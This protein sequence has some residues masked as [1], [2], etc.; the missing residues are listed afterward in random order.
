MLRFQD[1][2][3]L[4]LWLL[5]PI[6]ALLYFRYTQHRKKI[7]NKLGD[8]NLITRLIPAYSK[9]RQYVKLILSGLTLF[10]LVL[11]MANLQGN[12]KSQKIQ[13]K[14][15]DVIIA[16]D[17]SKSMLAKDVAPDRLQ[18]AKQCISK[19]LD[20]IGNNRVALVLFAG[21]SYMSVPLTV[22]ISAL[23]MNLATANPD[24]VPSQG[25]NLAA[26]LEMARKTFNS[27]ELRYKSIVLLSDGE[28][29]DDKA[30][31]EAKK[32][33]D[34]G[35]TIQTIGIGSEKGS[36]LFDPQTGT[37]KLDK[38]GKEVI[39]ILN[40]TELQQIASAGKGEYYRLYKPD[41][42]ANKLASAINKAEQRDF[43]VAL[44][45]DYDSYFQYFL[46]VAFLLLLV[47]FFIPEFK[48][49]LS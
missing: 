48:T 10:F 42:T 35:I 23:K 17:V 44:F 34:E 46:L 36:T 5:I 30:L 38:D 1:I 47:E 45:T 8:R 49:T 11:A 26:A 13:R 41:L 33:L 31:Q 40:E 18:A 15:I 28:D 9:N 37:N 14:G 4:W 2:E 21:R 29:H 16:L 43:G 3:V 39:S 24:V 27:K 25:T 32:A 12:A 22:D 19:L 6:L 7:L 20:Q